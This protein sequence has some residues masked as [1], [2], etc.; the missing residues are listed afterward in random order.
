M[1]KTS[2]TTIKR[3]IIV[4]GYFM[5]YKAKLRKIFVDYQICSIICMTKKMYL[6]C[7]ATETIGGTVRFKIIF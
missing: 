4:R 2:I 5:I 1:D 7:I 6:D 3:K